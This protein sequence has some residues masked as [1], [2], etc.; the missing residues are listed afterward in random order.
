MEILL[1]VLSVG[2]VVI[3]EIRIQYVIVEMVIMKRIN[4]VMNVSL[5]VS[6]VP[7]KLCA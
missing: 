4:I 1:N 7:Q 2:M 6:I 3:G 5:L